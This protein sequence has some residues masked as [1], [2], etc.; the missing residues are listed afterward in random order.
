MPRDKLACRDLP[1]KFVKQDRARNPSQ[2]HLARPHSQRGQSGEDDRARRLRRSAD[3]EHDAAPVLV[4]GGATFGQRVITGE[5]APLLLSTGPG[6]LTS[7][8]A[9]QEA[10][11]ASAP[12]LA[13][14]SLNENDSLTE[15]N[16]LFGTINA[17]RLTGTVDGSGSSIVRLTYRLNGAPEMPFLMDADKFAR[18][19]VDAIAAGRTY[20]VIPWQM[21][22]LAK[23][24][25]VLPNW[26][27]DRV[28]A[29]RPY[30]PRKAGA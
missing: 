11:A 4:R 6:A 20:T 18:A 29:R 16:P 24:L 28:M 9:L 14:S 22:V 7:L 26:L 8:A 13:I 10:A 3:D 2:L 19:A 21:G 1:L 12:V 25:R 27:Y 5:A 17:K 15:L 30:K 23:L